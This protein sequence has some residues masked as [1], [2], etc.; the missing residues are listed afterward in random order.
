MSTAT[1]I[2]EVV[3]AYRA[4]DP[5]G[6]LLASAAFHDLAPDDRAR[7]F[8]EALLQRTVENALDPEGLST[9]ARAVLERIHASRAR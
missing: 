6:A 9:T 3:S 5:R 8:D 7:A 1:L 2:E 4:R